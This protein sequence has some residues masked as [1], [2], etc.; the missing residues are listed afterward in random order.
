MN[1]TIEDR[2]TELLNNI[3]GIDHRSIPIYAR[4]FTRRHKRGW[5][6]PVST[7][8]RCRDLLYYK[9]SLERN[10]PY[11]VDLFKIE[12]RNNLKIVLL[13]LYKT[14]KIRQII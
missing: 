10:S 2:Y 4:E 12:D 3:E 13:D 14:I 11:Y 1:H 8:Q 9:E 6:I 5:A 7:Y